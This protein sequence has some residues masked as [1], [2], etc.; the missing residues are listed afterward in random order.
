MS[1][2]AAPAC[3]QPPGVIAPSVDFARCEG[4]AAC[5]V[6]C[7]EEVFEIRR[8]GKA[9]YRQLGLMQRLRLRVH[10]MR[11]AYTPNAAACR[12]CGRC[13]PACPER[14]IKLVKPR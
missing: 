6:V 9:D 1:R 7:P 11:V 12:G 8:I 5:A 3:Q 10:G 14:A 2:E 4:K 13:V